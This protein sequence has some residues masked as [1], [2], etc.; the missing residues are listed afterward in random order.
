M[1]DGG[2]CIVLTRDPDGNRRWAAELEQAGYTV[3][4]AP[5]IHTEPLPLTEAARRTL[6]RLP[7]FDWLVLT[8]PRVVPALQSLMRAA[9]MGAHPVPPVATVGERTAEAVRAAGWRVKFV[10][11]V[12]NANALAAGL[13]P[14]R[15]QN[16][17][18][19][20]TTIA[21]SGLGAALRARGATVTDLPVYSTTPVRS[22]V[23]QLEQSI[24]DG[25]IAFVVFASPSA[26]TGLGL[27]LA[28][29]N[30]ARVRDLPVIAVGPTTA[31]A[32]AAMGFRHVEAAPEPTV[33]GL[34]EV[35]NTKKF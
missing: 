31:A 5:M 18:V 29:D 34:M 11:R 16:I 19:A 20:R 35:I 24:A 13:E 14:T 2:K 26:I 15:D 4:L 25:C 12:A 22:S 23:P 3:C 33:R 7:E 21:T 32:A 8:S 28:P 30:L 1:N 27:S 17:L 10:P 6:Q 9:N